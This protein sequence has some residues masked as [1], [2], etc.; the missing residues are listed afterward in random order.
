M[1]EYKNTYLKAYSTE[2]NSDRNKTVTNNY[3][4]RVR[5]CFD[6]HWKVDWQY[7]SQPLTKKVL[8]KD[9]VYAIQG[10]YEPKIIYSGN[11]PYKTRVIM[12]GTIKWESKEVKSGDFTLDA[13]SLTGAM[14]TEIGVVTH[15]DPLVIKKAVTSIP[16]TKKFTDNTGEV[17]KAIGDT[18]LIMKKIEDEL[19]N[20]R[21]VAMYVFH[22]PVL[23]PSSSSKTPSYIEG[24]GVTGYPKFVKVQTRTKTSS[25]GKT[26]TTTTGTSQ[27]TIISEVLSMPEDILNPDIAK[28]KE[29]TKKLVES[30]QI[31][32]SSINAVKGT[33]TFSISSSGT[34]KLNEKTG[35][36]VE[37]ID[38][39]DK[40]GSTSCPTGMQFRAHYDENLSDLK[41]W[42]AD[43]VTASKGKMISY[44]ESEIATTDFSYTFYKID[45]EPNYDQTGS[46]ISG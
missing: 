38:L 23:S 5:L 14:D 13:E 6:L 26:E 2:N 40:I 15:T 34:V 37:F 43:L 12:F 22:K 1:A 4:Q 24:I 46:P 17:Y 25:T 30:D 9:V 20:L 44:I 29:K 3:S 36:S 45:N 33:S 31:S 39:R 7:V 10:G 41:A 18:D 16:K 11:G 28:I 27:S 8:G 21:L 42:E 19:L 35:T 32:T